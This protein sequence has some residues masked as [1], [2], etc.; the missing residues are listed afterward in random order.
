MGAKS[1]QKH[2]ENIGIN[3][4]AIYNEFLLWSALPKEV[5]FRSG[6]EDQNQ[7]A[8]HH[9]VSKDTLSLWKKRPEFMTEIRTVRDKWALERTSDIIDVIYQSAA[10]GNA[11]AQK[12]WLKYF[13]PLKPKEEKIPDKPLMH[14]DDLRVMIESLPEA[15]QDKYTMV[16]R[17]LM[18]D[19]FAMRDGR[20]DDL[21]HIKN[22]PRDPN[23]SEE[24]YE[25]R[26]L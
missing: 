17:E 7:F 10:K 8:E 23:E 24:D 12:L 13:E 14:P 20:M 22:R 21:S 16:I 1:I 2:S 19:C 18:D 9:G 25:G 5:R 4:I 6:I 26:L 3:K 11:A 15:L